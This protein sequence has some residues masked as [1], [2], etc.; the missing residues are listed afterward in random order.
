MK[1]ID[2][3]V[4]FLSEFSVEATDN[5]NLAEVIRVEDI[6]LPLAFFV[7]YGFVTSLTPKGEQRLLDVY[8]F[9]VDVANEQ[10]LELVDLAYTDTPVEPRTMKVTI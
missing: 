9:L 1:K 3:I 8:N 5:P 2:K 7:D 6:G 4:K 10:G